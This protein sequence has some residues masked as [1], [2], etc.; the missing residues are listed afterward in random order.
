MRSRVGMYVELKDGKVVCGVVERNN[1]K[2]R[3]IETTV[4]HTLIIQLHVNGKYVGITNYI[5]SS[6]IS[7]V[8]FDG[9]AVKVHLTC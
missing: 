7:R 1:G 2:T 9:I 3:V 6:N 4:A 8:E 5:H